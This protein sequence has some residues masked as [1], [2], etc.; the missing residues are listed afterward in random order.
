MNVKPAG[1]GGIGRDFDRLLWPE[2]GH[3]NY[4]AVPRVG[5]FQFSFVP[6]TTNHSRGG[7]C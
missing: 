5:V 7:E 6:A 1:E 3:L 2:V 4:L